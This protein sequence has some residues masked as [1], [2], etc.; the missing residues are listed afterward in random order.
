MESYALTMD[1]S[2]VY[3]EAFEKI[4]TML[5]ELQPDEEYTTFI[6]K[7]KRYYMMYVYQES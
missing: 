7:N 4:F 2:K 6:E 5:D 1:M 3:Q